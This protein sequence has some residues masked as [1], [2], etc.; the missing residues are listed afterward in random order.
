MKQLAHWPEWI[1]MITLR[2]AVKGAINDLMAT[3]PYPVR[4]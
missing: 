1:K 2:D 4:F 3:T